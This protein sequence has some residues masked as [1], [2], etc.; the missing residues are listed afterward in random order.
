MAVLYDDKESRTIPAGVAD[1]QI[2]KLGGEFSDG[3]AILTTIGMSYE[4]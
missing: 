2:I 1:N 3:G 4:F